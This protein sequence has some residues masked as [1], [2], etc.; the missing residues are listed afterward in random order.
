MCRWAVAYSAGI[1]H[2]GNKFLE[3]RQSSFLR[4]RDAF[5]IPQ[6]SPRRGSRQRASVRSIK[7]RDDQ[8]KDTHGRTSDVFVC[9]GPSVCLDSCLQLYLSMR[10][11]FHLIQ[12]DEAG[13][14]ALTGRGAPA[15][16][17]PPRTFGVLAVR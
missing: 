14:G 3:S 5:E 16:C 4:H 15:P 1:R 2:Q 7:Q 8:E 12:E 6:T 13:Q 11:V 17:Y 9:L 10:E